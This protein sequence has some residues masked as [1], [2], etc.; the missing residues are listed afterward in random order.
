MQNATSTTR[1]NNKVLNGLDNGMEPSRESTTAKSRSMVNAEIY[2]AL[3]IATRLAFP[4]PRQ[5][6]RLEL[7]P[8]AADGRS[9][10]SRAPR[11]FNGQ[12]ETREANRMPPLIRRE[13]RGGGRS[14]RLCERGGSRQKR[15]PREAIDTPSQ[16][17]GCRGE[18]VRKACWR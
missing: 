9:G 2:H 12:E 8:A 5:C 17:S 10:E 3:T 15:L 11:E 6:W 16:W 1:A 18:R 7:R 14:R 13:V 4:P